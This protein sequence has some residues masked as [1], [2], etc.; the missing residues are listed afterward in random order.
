VTFVRGVSVRNEYW[1]TSP[2]VA[3]EGCLVRYRTDEKWDGTS[4]IVI[5]THG[6]GSGAIQ[7]QS[8]PWFLSPSADALVATG[9]YVFIG[10]DAGGPNQ[11]SNVTA[12]DRIIAARDYMRTRG[13][14]TGRHGL[15]GY[16][17]GGFVAANYAKRYAA[18][19]AALWTY[20]G[21]FDLDWALKTAG[22]T[23]IT[24]SS[25]Y[26]PEAL[27]TF[28]DYASTAGWR[29]WD[30]PAS[31]RNF[32]FPWRITHSTDDATVP[33]GITQKF[34]ADVASPK[35]TYTEWPTGG[36]TGLFMNATDAEIVA[37]FD[38]GVWT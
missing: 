37:H 13:G 28:G 35:I 34:V 17:M 7:W 20:A 11:W 27:A 8:N 15:F 29:V 32:D 12:N 30:E 23:P 19:L 14:K 1:P 26:G 25:T 31:Y 33:V 24:S 10:I 2:Y 21:L 16:S 9:R 3:G 6:H 36:H 38:S 4:R 5:G 22:H 18:N